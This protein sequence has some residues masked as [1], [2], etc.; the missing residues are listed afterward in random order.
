MNFDITAIATATATVIAAIGGAM[1][2]YFNGRQKTL[3]E[4]NNKQIED[5]LASNKFQTE[6]LEAQ[7]AIVERMETEFATL[8]EEVLTL[9]VENKTMREDYEEEIKKLQGENRKLRKKIA[10]LEDQLKEK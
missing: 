9:R 3:G 10:E 4:M 8:K 6:R 1:A 5:L 7:R 2:Y